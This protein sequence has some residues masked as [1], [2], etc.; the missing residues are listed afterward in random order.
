M[1]DFRLKKLIVLGVVTV[2]FAGLATGAV[3]WRAQQIQTQMPPAPFLPGFSAQ[4]KNAQRIHIA[5]KAGSFDVAYSEGAGWTLPAKGNYPADFEQVRHLLIGLAALETIAPKT[6]R[7]D[8]LPFIGLDEPGNG[9][10]IVVSDAHGVA[11]ADI[12]TGKTMPLGDGTG[13]FVRRGGETQ[14]FLARAPYA[15]EPQLGPW[16]MQ[17]VYSI[18]AAR[19]MNVA[20]PAV[21]VQREH[22]SDQNYGMTGVATGKFNPTAVNGLAAAILDFAIADVRPVA[23]VDFAGARAITARTFDGVIL[24]MA[25]VQKPDGVWARITASAVPGA[26]TAFRQEADGI[27]ARAAPWAYKLGPE[28]ARALMAGREEF[29]APAGGQ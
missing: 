8:W 17:G 29:L 13:I 9:T 5:S 25:L 6:A 7:A 24:T 15:P 27:A 16:L 3:I 21:T 12:I 19:L 20:T 4:V 22:T 28:Q 14:S 26:V 18:N 2:V 23:A 11:L 1:T 10:H